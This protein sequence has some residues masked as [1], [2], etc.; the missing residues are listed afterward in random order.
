VFKTL[1]AKVSS[2]DLELFRLYGNSA[3][4]YTTDPQEKATHLTQSYSDEK[5]SDIAIPSKSQE[6]SH[7]SS[8]SVLIYK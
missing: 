3:H 7:C 8:P 4:P 5:I 2:Q 1:K 6:Q